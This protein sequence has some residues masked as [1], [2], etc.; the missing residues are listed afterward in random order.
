MQIG[1]ILKPIRARMRIPGRGF[2]LIEVLLSV[3]IFSAGV[4]AVLQVLMSST[5]ALSYV[6]QRSEANRLLAKKIWEIQMAVLQT[7]RLA[8]TQERGVLIGTDKTF[9]YQWLARPLDSKGA[10]HETKMELAWSQSGVKKELSRTFY[11]LSPVS[12]EEE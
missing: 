8:Q 5:M 2:T 6:L 9:D 3:V 10:L 4:I 1:N 11:V 12:H 7:G